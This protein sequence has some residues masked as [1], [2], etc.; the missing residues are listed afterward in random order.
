MN[1]AVNSPIHYQMGKHETID[2]IESTLGDK[3]FAAYCQGN[4]VKYLSRFRFKNGVEDLQK[5]E[6][7]LKKLIQSVQNIE[8]ETTRKIGEDVPDG[9]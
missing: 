3:G 6:W 7:Y 1:N 9:E 4:I 2:M 8:E 5:A